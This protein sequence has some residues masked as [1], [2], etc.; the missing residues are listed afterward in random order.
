MNGTHI[1][2]SKTM[3]PVAI[4]PKF[5]NWFSDASGRIFL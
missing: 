5:T 2:P 4:R 1:M 3:T